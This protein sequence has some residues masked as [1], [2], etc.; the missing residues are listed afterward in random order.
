[1]MYALHHLHETLD[2][3]VG[4]V[5]C[6]NCGLKF[7]INVLIQQSQ[8]KHWH[9]FH[10]TMKHSLI[11][12]LTCDF[13]REMLVASN[14]FIYFIF[15][16]PSANSVCAL[17]CALVCAFWWCVCNAHFAFVWVTVKISFHDSI[18]LSMAVAWNFGYE[19]GILNYL[20]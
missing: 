6:S 11:I 17:E 3:L 10:K 8:N 5:N 20:N 15:L 4:S 7:M 19:N 9:A 12:F 14:H 18:V 13:D 2:R 16:F 1:M